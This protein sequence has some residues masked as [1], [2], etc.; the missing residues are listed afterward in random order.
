MVAV[1]VVVVIIVAWHNSG[2]QIP[3]PPPS[4]IFVIGGFDE[5]QPPC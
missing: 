3:A 4:T 1:S 2:I 5:L